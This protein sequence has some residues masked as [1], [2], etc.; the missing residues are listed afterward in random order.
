MKVITRDEKDAYD[1]ITHN[2][3]YLERE[4]MQL[5]A[6]MLALNLQLD[7][8][9]SYFPAA[10][11]YKESLTTFTCELIKENNK[12]AKVYEKMLRYLQLMITNNT[13]DYY[14]DS[15]YYDYFGKVIEALETS[16]H[17]RSVKN[18]VFNYSMAVGVRYGAESITIKASYD[19]DKPLISDE[20]FEEMLK[21]IPKR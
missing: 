4:R 17:D 14:T 2:L 8:I 5:F 6:N 18:T 16:K 15:Y 1:K 7:Q 10:L 19:I 13:Y 21:R 20:Q 11:D 9:S 3:C 12:E